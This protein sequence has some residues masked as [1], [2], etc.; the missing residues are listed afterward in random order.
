VIM[1]ASKFNQAVT[2][3]AGSNAVLNVSGSYEAM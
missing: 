1:L 2:L 3:P